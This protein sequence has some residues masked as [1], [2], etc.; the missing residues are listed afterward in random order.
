MPKQK[1]QQQR[2]ATNQQAKTP[3]KLRFCLESWWLDKKHT[4]INDTVGGWNPANQ[5]S[6]VV[7]PTIYRVLY[8]QGGAGFQPS[9]VLCCDFFMGIYHGS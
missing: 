4:D 7:Y 1:N 5:L 2:I 9:T 6:L 8:I 3:P